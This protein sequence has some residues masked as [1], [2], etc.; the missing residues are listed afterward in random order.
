MCDFM[1]LYL[2]KKLKL[3]FDADKILIVQINFD[4]TQSTAVMNG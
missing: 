2:E 3:N 1:Q 4:R